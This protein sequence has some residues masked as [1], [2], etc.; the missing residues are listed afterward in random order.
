MTYHTYIHYSVMQ[1][2]VGESLRLCRCMTLMFAMPTQYAVRSVS[3]S[4]EAGE[5][6]VAMQR[7]G[8][9]LSILLS[10]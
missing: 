3:H 9:Q 2:M 7:G 5:F 1:D 8:M 10:V 4:K 6:L